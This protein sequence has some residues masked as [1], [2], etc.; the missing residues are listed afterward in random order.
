MDS[1]SVWREL[2]I[3]SETRAHGRQGNSTVGDPYAV[4]RTGVLE[5]VIHQ[6]ARAVVRAT[7]VQGG[8][9]LTKEA[10]AVGAP[11]MGGITIMVK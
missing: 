7:V 10:G 1:D 5:N 2:P 11:G 8:W 6:W 4:N 9:V 3:R